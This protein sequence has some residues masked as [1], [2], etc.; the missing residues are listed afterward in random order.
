MKIAVV[1]DDKRLHLTMT[2]YFLQ[3]QIANDCD[4][5]VDYFFSCE[6]VYRRFLS[7]NDYDL[8]FVDTDFPQM[9][10]AEFGMLLR[11]RLHNYET[12]IVFLSAAKDYAAELFAVR[13]AGLLS[14]PLSYPQFSAC[15]SGVLEEF[16]Y[17]SDFLDYT[18]ENTRHRIR[19]K[20]ILYLKS[21]GKKVA[22][23][24][25]EDSFT[26]YG[27]ITDLIE[28]C[29]EQF[30]CISRGEFVNVQHVLSASPHEVHLTGNL[31][32]H[33]SRSRMQAVRARL[34]VL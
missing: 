19:I 28:G 8:L 3:F 1:N 9:H 25:K 31:V 10:G 32:L 14:K 15:L 6:E 22:F 21:Q 5:S 4:L 29:A 2:Q 34:S 7:G 33:I 30:L 26:V 18:L 11:N 12:R 27:K 20:E 13:P 16:S 24:T 17:T 23:H